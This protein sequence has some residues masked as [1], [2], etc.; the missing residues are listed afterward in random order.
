MFIHPARC[1]VRS[2]TT[3]H[4]FLLAP[5]QILPRHYQ[6]TRLFVGALE[7]TK[8]S[9]ASTTESKSIPRVTLKRNR[10]TKAFR[11]GTQLVFSK[12][13]D[14]TPKKLQSGDLVAVDVPVSN[15]ANNT[16]TTVVGVGVYNPDSMYRVRILCHTFLNADLKLESM[17]PEIALSTILKLQF[18]KALETRRT[19]GLPSSDTDTFRLFNGEGDGLSGLAVDIV[20]G[21][22]AVIMSSAAWCQLHQS[23]ILKS[24]QEV[25]PEMDL[26]WKTTPSRLRQDGYEEPEESDEV[27]EEENEEP[28]IVTENALCDGKK[29]LDLC[30]YHGGF[31]L[32]AVKNNAVHVTGVD[33][34]KDAI[35]TYTENAKL[36]G[37][38]DRIDF[39]RSDISTFMKSCNEKY[40]VIVLDP[41][42]LAPSMSTLNKASR[43]YKSLNKDALEL[44]SNDGGIFMTCTCSSAMTQKDG[45]N[46]FLQTI[47]QASLSARREITLLR[48]SGAAPCHTQSPAS[49]PAGNYLTAAL[50]YVK[51]KSGT[52]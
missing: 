17:D 16:Q 25:L 27:P 41:P 22:T 48:V 50:F 32:N 51:P 34:S 15:D 24:L 45:G 6:A 20:G 5:Q 42:K 40:D 47:Q 31:S 3:K 18:D 37:F 28:V 29:V 39:V 23:S 10:Q 8:E 19:I 21:N 38:E 2:L 9:T 46:F 12:S 36:N 26:V 35:D 13:I 4:S 14:K 1:F 43:K 11:D 30:C 33:S 44:M 52:D 49:F 7:E